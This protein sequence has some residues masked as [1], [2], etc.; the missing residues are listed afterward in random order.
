MV[1]TIMKAEAQGRMLENEARK[2]I[3]ESIKENKQK[4]YY[5]SK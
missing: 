4:K 5:D 3:L 2:N 1:K